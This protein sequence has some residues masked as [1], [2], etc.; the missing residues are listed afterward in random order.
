MLVQRGSAGVYQRTP[1]VPPDCREARCTLCLRFCFC[2]VFLLFSSLLCT[3]LARK[4]VPARHSRCCSQRRQTTRQKSSPLLTPPCSWPTQLAM[5]TGLTTGTPSNPRLEKSSRGR[6]QCLPALLQS[7]PSLIGTV[8]K[9]TGHQLSFSYQHPLCT[10]P[11]MPIQLHHPKLAFPP[12]GACALVGT[13]CRID[14]LLP[15]TK[16]KSPH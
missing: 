10:L 12:H 14:C 13:L 6:K 15:R 3:E 5:G 9:K 2:Y 1:H 8:W 16:Q 11:M 7:S 4:A